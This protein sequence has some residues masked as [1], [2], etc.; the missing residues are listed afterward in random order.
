MQEQLYWNTQKISRQAVTKWEAN[1]SK[2]NS[3]NLIKLAQLFGVDVDT[4]LG[5]KGGEKSSTQGEVSIG[6]IVATAVFSTI[7]PIFLELFNGSILPQIQTYFH[8]SLLKMA[9]VCLKTL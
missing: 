2:P 6:K 3:D 9:G 7:S 4:L 5:N 8:L 1:T